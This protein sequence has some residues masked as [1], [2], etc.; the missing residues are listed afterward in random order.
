MSGN[1]H[2]CQV[3]RNVLELSDSERIR[4]ILGLRWIGYPRAKQVLENLDILMSHPKVHRMPNLLI[5]APTNNGK[6]AIVRRF[7]EMHPIIDDLRAPKTIVPVLLVETPPGPEEGRLLSSILELLCKPLSPSAR[8]DQ[9]A[10]QVKRMLAA[11][12]TK[13]LII[14]EIHNILTGGPSRQRHFLNFLKGLGNELQIPIVAVGTEQARNAIRT[15]E[16]MANRFE[17]MALPIWHDNEEYARLL[18]SFERLIPLRQRSYLT[19]RDLA[20]K[21]LGLSEGTIGEIAQVI[22]RAAVYAI[23]TH[24]E[25]ITLECLN[26]IKY[27]SPSTRR[28]R[29]VA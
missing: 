22:K 18:A 3:A 1:D 11:V 24:A 27:V 4:H 25:R 17:E 8:I 21:I 9:R 5:T 16:Q 19:S 28:G 13:I 29:R 20:V 12:E 2:L 10:F 15:D 14:D 23:R 26:K 6:T 7:A